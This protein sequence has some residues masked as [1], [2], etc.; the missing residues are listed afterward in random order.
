MQGH[1]TTEHRLSTANEAASKALHWKPRG[2]AEEQGLAS[3]CLL[4]PP[5]LHTTTATAKAEEARL[6]HFNNVKIASK[7]R[8]TS[9]AG[10]RY[11]CTPE[12]E[13]SC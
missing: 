5:L 7:T 2:E 3:P 1:D 13:D 12:V 10:T 4:H 8:K 6:E 11:Y 9:E